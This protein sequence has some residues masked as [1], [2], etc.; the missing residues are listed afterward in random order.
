[1]R[2]DTDTKSAAGVGALGGA[3]R[4][5][6]TPAD[7]VG[8]LEREYQIYRSIHTFPGWMFPE[9]YLPV[10]SV[11]E[12]SVVRPEIYAATVASALATKGSGGVF[13][14]PAVTLSQQALLQ[15]LRDRTRFGTQF[16]SLG[17]APPGTFLGVKCAR[18]PQPP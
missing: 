11:H 12:N 10:S 13:F 2:A 7:P 14:A 1:M 15:E 8:R 18:V 3:A 6:K 5:T 16:L 17:S 4:A 9:N